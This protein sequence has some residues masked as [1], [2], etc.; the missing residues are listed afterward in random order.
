MGPGIGGETMTTQLED[1]QARA[2]SLRER[3]DA[4]KKLIA[5]QL[6]QG[7]QQRPLQEKAKLALEQAS[8]VRA[9]WEIHCLETPSTASK[10][11]D[12]LQREYQEFIKKQEKP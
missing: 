12:L 4:R 5:K 7:Q 6:K 11:N 2:Y 8:Y 1:I 10:P 3:M 9:L